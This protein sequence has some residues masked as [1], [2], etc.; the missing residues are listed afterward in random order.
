[1]KYRHLSRFFD[2]TKQDSIDP[3][4]KVYFDD[5]TLAYNTLS[6]KQSRMEYDEYISQQQSVSNY[7][8]MGPK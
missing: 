4:M 8:N 7:W 3:T 6:S 1:M 2:P 5:I